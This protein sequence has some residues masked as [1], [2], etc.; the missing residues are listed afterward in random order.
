MKQT[1]GYKKA[2]TYKG[3]VI[4]N[5]GYGYNIYKNGKIQSPET[6]E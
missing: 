2:L 5:I 4:L 6:V 1:I 3:Y